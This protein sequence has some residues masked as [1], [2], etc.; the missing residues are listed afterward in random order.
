MKKVSFLGWHLQPGGRSD[1]DY[2]VMPISEISKL[3][4]ESVPAR[5]TFHR[6]KEVW[7]DKDGYVFPVKVARNEVAYHITPAWD[8]DMFEEEGVGEQGEDVSPEI[9]EPLPKEDVPLES[10]LEK[11]PCPPILA[12]PVFGDMTPLVMEEDQQS[13]THAGI[14]IKRHPFSTRPPHIH[15][16]DWETKAKQTKQMLTYQ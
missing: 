12:E 7:H 3:V 14:K 5:V 13:E 2:V 6:V 10:K 15:P 1:G 9:Q 4:D 8:V 11:E 16:A